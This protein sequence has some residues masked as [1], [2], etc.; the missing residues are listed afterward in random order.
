MVVFECG[1]CNESVKK[2][3]LEKHLQM[4]RAEYVSCIDCNQRFTWDTWA[5][6]TSCISEAQKYQ[7]NL[8]QAKEN[9][10]KG[11]VKQ[12]AWTDN[13]LKIIE[14]PDSGISPG[15]KALVEK[16]MDFSNIPRKPRPFANFVKNSVKI[17][18]QKKIDDMWAV[19]A[20]ANVRPAGSA[21]GAA[22]K[23]EAKPAKRKWEGWQKALDE[24]DRDKDAKT[25][26]RMR[27]AKGKERKMKVISKKGGEVDDDYVPKVIKGRMKK[28]VAFKE[29]LVKRDAEERAVAAAILS[30][31]AS[32]KPADVF[33]ENKSEDVAKGK[34][35]KKKGDQADGAEQ[36]KTKSDQADGA[37]QK[38]AKTGG[39][40]GK[41]QK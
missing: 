14:D 24:E 20:A 39:K 27:D 16:L 22:A 10:N 18:D 7:G 36:K 4:C 32:G 8:Y 15:T 2:P 17:W 37:E 30:P 35:R 25:R 6:H 12:D 26:R 13:I 9:S 1:K 40:K 23:A 34:K 31:D 41:K 33:A 5:Q 29:E 19:I 21:P 11:Q 28:R 38:K 3:K